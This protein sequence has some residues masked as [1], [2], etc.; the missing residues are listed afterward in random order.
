MTAKTKAAGPSTKGIE[1]VATRESFRRGGHAFGR[2]AVTLPLSELTPEQLEA[3]R[4]EA[5]L[6]VRDVDIP[7][8]K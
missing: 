7:A 5:M 6:I 2:E 4:N 1:V 3:I 8:A